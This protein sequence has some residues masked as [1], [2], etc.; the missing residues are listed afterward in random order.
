MI[1]IENARLFSELERRNA[2]LQERTEQLEVSNRQVSE[3]LEQQTALSEVLRVIASSPTNV[4]R[5]LDTISETAA[6]ICGSDN[7]AIR[8]VNGDQYV[9]AASF[10]PLAG[11][12]GEHLPIDPDTP[13][14]RVILSGQTFALDDVQAVAAQEFPSNAA[15]YRQ[16]GV[17][18]LVGVPM[19]RD[20]M[21]IGT[22]IMR[23]M[24]VRPYTERQIALLEAF[25]DQAVIAIEN[26]RLFAELQESNRQ[27]TES[28]DQQTAL[29]EVLRVIAASPNNVQLVL[30][31]IAERPSASVQP[32][33]PLCTAL[34]AT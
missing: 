32:M 12:V 30:D 15:R 13:S 19:L 31:T 3:S 1:A 26:A 24:E 10:G 9:R 21:V 4:Q 18:S 6:R 17:R 14:G 5:V 11:A 23:R 25:A 33:T 8:L 7:A 16:L 2:E 22:I 34:T 28:L 20:D 29:S 27:V